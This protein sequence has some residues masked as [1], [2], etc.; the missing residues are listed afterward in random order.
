MIGYIRGT[1]ADKE[2]NHILIIT[3]H[4]GYTVTVSEKDLLSLQKGSQVELFTEMV[5]R[6]NEISLFGFLDQEDKKMFNILNE[7]SG[8]GPR[9]S[10]GIISCL[11]TSIL[12]EAIISENMPVL[13]KL[14]G[15]GKKTAQRIILELKEKLQKSHSVHSEQSKPNEGLKKQQTCLSAVSET[16]SALGYTDREIIVVLPQLEDMD[17]LSEQDLVKKA[18]KIIG[19]TK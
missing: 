16:L 19:Q 12:K 18:L 14:P 4:I 8:I 3:D 9:S 1:I 11:E 7:V 17:G 13:L 10:M 6:E 15:I 5:V 2:N